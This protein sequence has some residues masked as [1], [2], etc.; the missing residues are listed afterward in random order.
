MYTEHLTI[1]DSNPIPNLQDFN[2]ELAGKTAFSKLDLVR[3]YHHIQE[4]PEDVEKTAVVTPLD[5][6]ITKCST[7]LPEDYSQYST[8]AT[9]C[10]RF[11]R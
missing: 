5:V 8:R 7:I 2:S 10:I 6:W 9:I 11:Y 4:E 3:A 1:P